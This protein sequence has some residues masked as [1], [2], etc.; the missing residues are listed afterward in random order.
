M[1]ET[2]RDEH[3]IADDGEDQGDDLVRSDDEVRA[4]IAAVDQAIAQGYNVRTADA[5]VLRDFA[6]DVLIARSRRW[7][8]SSGAEPFTE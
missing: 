5:L 4:A 8:R 2:W 1:S 7:P 6:R 3:L